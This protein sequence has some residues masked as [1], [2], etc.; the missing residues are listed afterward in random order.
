MRSLPVI[1]SGLLLGLFVAAA[2]QQSIFSKGNK[3]KMGLPGLKVPPPYQ[4]AKAIDSAVTDRPN[5]LVPEEVSTWLPTMHWHPYPLVSRFQYRY[6]LGPQRRE[7]IRLKQYI[8]GQARPE[9]APA[10]LRKGIERHRLGAVCFAVSNP[11]AEEIRQVLREA[12]FEKLKL[13][14]SHEIWMP[15]TRIN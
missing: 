3:V 9:N 15:Q 4:V 2:S 7:R 1:M 5:V 14:L 12:G 6:K 10:V 13:L 8:D 11:W